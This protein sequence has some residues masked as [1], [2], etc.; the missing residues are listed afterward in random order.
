M[1]ACLA[2]GLD[3]KHGARCVPAGEDRFRCSCSGICDGDDD[4]DPVCGSDHVSY[5]NRCT[6]V[7]AGC[8]KQLNISV[9]ADVTCSKLMV[10]FLHSGILYILF[11]I[12]Y[13][14]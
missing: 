7:E 2:H 14:L 9:I 1:D 12:K 6:L 13:A 3:C 8:E 5:K 4:D 10:A 11:E